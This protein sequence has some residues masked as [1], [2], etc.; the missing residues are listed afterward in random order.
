MDVQN[1][2][3]VLDN[4]PVHRAAVDTE[5]DAEVQIRFLLAYYSPV[6]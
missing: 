1:A 6:Y 3:V 4:V 2:T 5:P